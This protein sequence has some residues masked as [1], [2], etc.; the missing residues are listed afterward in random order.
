VITVV[1]NCGPCEEYIAKCIASLR[2]QT[3][4]EWRCMI[5]VDG[6]PAS[7]P[8]GP[9]AS[10]PPDQTHQRALE[11]IDADPRITLIRNSRRLYA[12]ANVVNAIARSGGGDAGGPAGGDAG[13][14]SDDIIVILDGDDWF[15]TNRALEIIARTYDTTGCWMTYGSWISNARPNHGRWPAY[16]D[17]TRD[18]RRAE[19]LGTAV[20]TFRRW[21]WDRIDDR[22]LRDDDGRYFRVVEDQAYMLPMLEMSTTRRARHIAEVLMVYNRA[23]PQ[24]VGNVM[25][26]EMRRAAAAVRARPPYEPL[27]SQGAAPARLPYIGRSSWQT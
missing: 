20:R 1:T 26:D 27:D 22:D 11:A 24:C 23:N 9:A 14:P 19:W 6:A 18:F 8:A 17:G 4:R 2:A 15:A 13:A 25:L 10:P 5:T 12:M 3:L 16:P 7:P 21:L